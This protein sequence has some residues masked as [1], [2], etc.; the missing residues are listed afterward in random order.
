M[1]ISV[2][3]EIRNIKS[4]KILRHLPSDMSSAIGGSI[5]NPATNA[6]ATVS[7]DDLGRLRL[8]PPTVADASER[9]RDQCREFSSKVNE[10]SSLVGD[11]MAIVEA[12]AG[13]IEKQKLKTIALRTAVE[14]EPARRVAELNRIS[15]LLR[16]RQM[17]LDR[18]M[19]QTE[20]YAKM[21]QEQQGVLDALI[22]K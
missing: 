7:F 18:L 1:I 6:A 19:A 2:W 12:R 10:F 15:F 3:R 8:I 17:Q 21:E 11:I 14:R 20:T 9:L 13:E 5:T 16:E 4:P 22:A